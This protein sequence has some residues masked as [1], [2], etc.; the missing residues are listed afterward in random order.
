[1]LYGLLNVALCA[2]WTVIAYIGSKQLVKF[3]STKVSELF[4]I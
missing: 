3:K 1:M 2:L 4:V